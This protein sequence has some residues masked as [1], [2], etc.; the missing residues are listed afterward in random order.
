V[1]EIS[2]VETVELQSAVFVPLKIGCHL[3]EEFLRK[4]GTARDNASSETAWITA[5]IVNKFAN[6]RK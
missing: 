4:F 6:Q 2:L 1:F 5:V 3:G